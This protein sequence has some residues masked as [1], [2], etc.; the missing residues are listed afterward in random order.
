MF[1]GHNIYI[2]VKLFFFQRLIDDQ[3]I[4][5]ASGNPKHKFIYGFYLYCVIPDKDK[6]TDFSFVT[7]LIEKLSL[8]HCLLDQ[9]YLPKCGIYQGRN[10]NINHNKF[11]KLLLLNLTAISECG[12]LK[13]SEVV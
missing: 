7:R 10:L 13:R 6:G 12:V 9:A 2:Y 4:V 3:V 8:Y 11:W 1:R 5:H